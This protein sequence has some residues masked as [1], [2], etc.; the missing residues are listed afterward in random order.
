MFNQGGMVELT[1]SS[2]FNYQSLVLAVCSSTYQTALSGCHC[3]GGA[4][5]VHKVL[6]QLVSLMLS[7]E[8]DP[9][10]LVFL[11]LEILRKSAKAGCTALG[12]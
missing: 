3:F 1:A 11:L 12:K 9:G 7:S 10:F 2:T 6:S 4:E 5:K 8:S